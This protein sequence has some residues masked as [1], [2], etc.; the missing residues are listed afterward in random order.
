MSRGPRRLR[1]WWLYGFP[2]GGL[3]RHAEIA[4]TRF[5]KTKLSQKR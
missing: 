1:S 4:L 3:F 5:G 2:I